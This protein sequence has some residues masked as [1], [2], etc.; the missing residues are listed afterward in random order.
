[1]EV[2]RTPQTQ[3]R[4]E[5]NRL[6]QRQN[7][8]NSIKTELGVL[9]SR[10]NALKDP[11]LYNSRALQVSAGTVASAR[12]DTGAV[13]GS[14]KFNITQ[15]ATASKFSGTPNAGQR[16]SETADVSGVTLAN[17]GFATAVS[18]G[19]FTVNGRQITLATTDSLQDVFDQIAAATGNAVTASYDPDTDKISLA[20]AGEIVL[21]S[22]TDTSNFLQVAKLYNNGTGAVASSGAL[23]GVK[24]GA[25]LAQ[26]NLATPVSDGGSGAGEFKI[27]GVAI[28]FNASTDTVSSVLERIN[29]SSAG[30]TAGYDAA[31]DRFVLTNRSTGDMG[32]ALED[33]TGNF[34]AAT[35]LDSGTLT[36]GKNLLYTV[37][38]GEPLTSQSNTITAASSGIAGLTVTALA[39]GVTTVTVSADTE[40]IKSAI[41][42]FVDA[43]NR[44]QSV[45]DTQTASST[46]S[47]GVVT[48]GTLASESDAYDIA[49]RLRSL[50]FSQ[51]TGLDGMFDHLADLGYK[52]SGDDNK[53]TLD[54]SAQLDEALNSNLSGVKSL[55]SD[56]TQGV[57][58]RLAAYLE[59]TIGDDGTLV[60][61]QNRLT[62][63]SSDIDT[64][65]AEL[66]RLVQTNREA[67]VAK[68]V[69]METAQ[70][71]FSSQLSF[72]QGQLASFS[73]SR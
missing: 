63:Q 6:N 55:F 42:G 5:Q 23:G 65:I 10:V 43:Y 28:T 34:L 22:A 71:K 33:V 17:A 1:M 11:A 40:K 50:A 18:A 3:L 4:T 39:E 21:G 69:A 24:L 31:T 25:T 66:E 38:D 73:S 13:L 54:D 32:I 48:A 15:L 44:A 68:F 47:K 7:A 59:R 30:V 9:Q 67:M 2:E 52:T 27:N 29:N 53:L 72:L 58:T 64:Q 26:S 46:N 70:A 49:T 19:T 56:A 45:I 16:L 41:T 57:A 14:Y 20:S 37:N 35:G 62:K 51:I 8:Y 36:R 61:H 12:V 60:T